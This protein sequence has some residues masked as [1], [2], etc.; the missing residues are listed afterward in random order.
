LRTADDGNAT[1]LLFLDLSA[2]FDTI[3]HR[4]LWTLELNFKI[5]LRAFSITPN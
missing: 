5:L 3:D 1:A 4:V 2:A